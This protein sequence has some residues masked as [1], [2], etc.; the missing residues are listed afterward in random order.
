ME[1]MERYMQERVFERIPSNVQVKFYYGYSVYFGTITNCS[2]SGI[3]VRTNKIFFPLHLHSRFELFVLFN[4]KVLKVPVKVGRI[5]KVDGI[6]Y[7]MGVEL[8]DITENYLEFLCS[9]R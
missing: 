5:E 6:Y 4:N 8:L 3:F 2:E 9:V 1:N 7:G